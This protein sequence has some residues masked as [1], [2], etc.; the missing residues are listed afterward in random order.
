MHIMATKIVLEEVD[1]SND[2]SPSIDFAD[3]TYASLDIDE[4]WEVGY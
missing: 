4:R 2:I 1:G 3:H